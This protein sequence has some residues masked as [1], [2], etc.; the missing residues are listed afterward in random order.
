MDRATLE[1]MAWHSTAQNKLTITITWYQ[2]LK[3]TTWPQYCKCVHCVDSWSHCRYSDTVSYHLRMAV[4]KKDGGTCWKYYESQDT[5]DLFEP[6]RQYVIKNHKKVWIF[7][8]VL[9]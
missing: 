6:V 5:I 8:L 4:R 9:L 7:Y 3:G 2:T 1:L